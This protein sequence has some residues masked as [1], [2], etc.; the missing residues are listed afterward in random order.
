MMWH[1]NWAIAGASLLWWKIC[2]D[3]TG[4][5]AFGA[6]Y[7][8]KL[9]WPAAGLLMGFIVVGTGLMLLF[10]A[11][12]HKDHRYRAI[13]LFVII[14]ALAALAMV[15]GRSAEALGADT[16]G[17]RHTL[18]RHWLALYLIYGSG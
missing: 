5:M 13:S 18:C 2:Q 17:P 1:G 8:A 3:A 6:G 14:A 7:A 9:S 12:K 11:W 15:E 4:L 10:A 16:G